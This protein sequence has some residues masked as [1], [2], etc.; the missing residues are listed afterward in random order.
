MKM[1]KTHLTDL[2]KSV[3]ESAITLETFF[4]DNQLPWP[5]FDEHGP[6]DLSVS[7]EMQQVNQKTVEACQELQELL[8]GSV[9]LLRP[10]VCGTQFLQ[11]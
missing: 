3:L 11:Q 10:V 8:I 9:M 1:P 4:N 6:S 7:P 2:A 5:S